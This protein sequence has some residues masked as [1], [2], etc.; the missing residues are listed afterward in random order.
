MKNNLIFGI[1]IILLVLVGIF[2]F[3]PKPEI[4][5]F[6]ECAAAGNPVGESYP[7]QCWTSDGKH[8]IEEIDDYWRLD[9]IELRQHETEKFYGCFG[10]NI[11][12][13]GP[14][15]CIDP[16]PEM[17]FVLETEDRHCN[18]DFEIIEKK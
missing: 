14:A 5:N 2:I 11:P 8:F 16:V 13:K 10:C 17:K 1:I 4:T 7:R 3:Q 18:S 15:L 12:K 9:G 6:E